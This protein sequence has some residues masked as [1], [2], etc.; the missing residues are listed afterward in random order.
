MEQKTKENDNRLIQASFTAWQI[1]KSNGGKVSWKDYLC[2]LGL[3]GKPRTSSVSN[4]EA[5]KIADEITKA[6]GR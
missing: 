3:A 4:D 2:S 5:M 6:T 1:I